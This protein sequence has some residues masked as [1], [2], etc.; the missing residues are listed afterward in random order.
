LHVGA[1]ASIGLP[2]MAGIKATAKIDGTLD[3]DLDPLRNGFGGS[4]H[5]VLIQATSTVELQISNYVKYGWVGG[6][7]KARR[8]WHQAAGAG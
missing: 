7:A 6:R 1:E 5:A 8:Y 2:E 3:V 4:D